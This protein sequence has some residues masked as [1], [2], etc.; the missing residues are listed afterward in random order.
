M[1][2]STMVPCTFP[3]LVYVQHPESQIAEVSHVQIVEQTNGDNAL[4]LSV[5]LDVYR[6]VSISM[7]S[8]H[9]R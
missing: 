6:H 9:V 7:K 2:P 8:H 1:H 4:I 3:S 5:H